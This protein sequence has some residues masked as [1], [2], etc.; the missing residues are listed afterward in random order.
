MSIGIDPNLIYPGSPDAPQAMP[1]ESEMV[2]VASFV[3]EGD[4]YGVD[5]NNQIWRWDVDEGKWL[6]VGEID[7]G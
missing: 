3:L 1:E 4:L 2:F 7:R 6:K 5:D